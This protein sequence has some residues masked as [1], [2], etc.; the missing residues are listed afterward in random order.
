MNKTSTSV[1]H[2]SPGRFKLY[3]RANDSTVVDLTHVLPDGSR[4]TD[5]PN[6][7]LLSTICAAIAS[8]QPRVEGPSFAPRI[9]SIFILIQWM[10]IR[11]IYRFGSL[12][13]EHFQEF[14]VDFS[15]GLD[16]CI[17]AL[18][19]MREHLKTLAGMAKEERLRLKPFD[20][21]EAARIPPTYISQLPDVLAL[22]YAF[23]ETG[24]KALDDAPKA[25]RLEKLKVTTLSTRVGG[26]Q[27]LWTCREHLE[28][29]ASVQPYPDDVILLLKKLGTPKQQ[30]EVVPH[31]I[32]MKLLLGVM[33]MLMTVGPAFLDWEA[34]RDLKLRGDRRHDEA[35]FQRLYELVSERWGHAV[36][37]DARGA[38]APYVPVVSLAKALIPAACQIAV[39]AYVGKRKVEIDHLE[40]NCI[41]GAPSEGRRLSAYIAKRQAYEAR[42]CPEVVAKAVELMVRYHGYQGSEVKPL[43]VQRG[44][45][46]A[47][48]GELHLDAFA[49]LVGAREYVDGQGNKLL[50]HWKKHQL[51]RLFVIYYIWRY[52]DSSFLVLRHHLGHGNE[53][54]AAFY[55]RLASDENFAD[56]VDEAGIFTV[57]KLREVANGGLVGPFAQVMAKRIERLQARLK[58]ASPMT[59][60]AVL[61]HLVNVEGLR[62]LAGP[63]GYCGCKATAANLRRAKCRQGKHAD[64]PKHPIFNTPIPESSS[65]ETCAGCHF[66]CTGPSRE[67]HWNNV[68][69]RLDKAIAGGR[70]G[71]L[72]VHILQQRRDKVHA[73]VER[74]F[75]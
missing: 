5:R 73:A 14:L 45:S 7:H 38:T 52:E 55:A 66:H 25:S 13:R 27:M 75:G 1:V 36:V 60:D 6:S 9:G 23:I 68:V 35:K 65:E 12:G 15:G 51:R 16:H 30:T 61:E 2:V 59:L 11:S 57:E 34:T 22:A 26:I 53:M 44:T 28:D 72:A 62:L 42:P 56:L 50:W 46:K 48:R 8:V 47:M 43:F 20:L 71:S 24:A 31:A 58:L 41:S 63:W 32:A 54:E 64:R 69:L 33:D 29:P 70:P 37:T 74:F 19:R 4:L 49:E 21:F 40:S 18:P 17:S 3:N 10:F 67:P 39:G